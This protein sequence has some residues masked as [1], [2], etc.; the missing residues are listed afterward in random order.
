MTTI[1]ADDLP[2]ARII[3]IDG[4]SGSGKSTIAREL[5]KHVDLKVLETGS[6]YRAT[7]LLCLENRVSVDDEKSIVSLIEDMHFRYEDG[8]YLDSRNIKEDIR[9]HEVA[10]NVSHVSV[11]EKVRELLTQKMRHWIVQHG[12][13]IIEGRDITTVVAPQAKIRIFIDAPEEI[14]AQRRQSDPKDNTS[15]RSEEEIKSVIS[16]RDKIDSSRKASPLTK[17]PGV[18]EIDT[19]KNSIDEI[20][21]GILESFKSGNPIKL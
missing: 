3:A 18:Y 16:M 9:S 19:S 8:P 7:T 13:G 5:A 4:T 11:H 12:G 20:V 2:N 21:S 17:A 15:N 10:I 6:L 14:R 1:S